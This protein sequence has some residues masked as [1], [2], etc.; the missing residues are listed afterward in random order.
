MTSREDSEIQATGSDL[1][2]KQED[3]RDIKE[4]KGT[5]QSWASNNK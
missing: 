3:R 5:T 4:E 1:K 2:K